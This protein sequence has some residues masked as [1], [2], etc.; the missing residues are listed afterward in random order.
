LLKHL[1]GAGHTHK[2]EETIESIV[3]PSIPVFTVHAFLEDVL[4][5]F[6]EAPVILV[7]DND[8]PIGILTKIDVLDFIA[9]KI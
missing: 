4:P 1:W 7:T 5:K 3:E 8:R 6:F 9:Q 2:P